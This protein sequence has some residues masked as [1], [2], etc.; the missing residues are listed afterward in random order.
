MRKSIVCLTR[1]YQKY[2]SY[3]K[4]IKRN[5]H[6]EQKLQD[7]EIE[8]VIFHEGNIHHQTEIQKE[9][10]SLKMKF[11][12]V[13]KDGIAFKKEYESLTIDP[14]TSFHGWGYRHMC[15]FWFVD[16]WKF[17]EEYDFIIR[18]D[19]DCYI[20]FI[21][22]NIFEKLEKTP[23]VYGKDNIDL[24]HVTKGMNDHTLQFMINHGYGSLDRKLPSG[25]YTNVIGFYLPYLRN[26]P[27]LHNY[28]ESVKDTK[29]IYTQ[30]WGDLPLWGEA[31]HYILGESSIRVD[32]TL[33]YYHES[34]QC[35]VNR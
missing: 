24:F 27:I 31:I 32:T 23:I 14:E 10:P 18:I 11:I 6:I 34:H 29:C 13:A 8:I 17:V 2:S 28:I 30:R 3:H 25:P 12:D 15:S 21:P 16:F 33:N 35:Y 4:L 9:T 20:E 5:K 22:D 19:E 1:G 26:I 7:K